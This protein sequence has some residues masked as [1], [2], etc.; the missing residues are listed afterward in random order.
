MVVIG[1]KMDLVWV[2]WFLIDTVC[3][4]LTYATIQRHEREVSSEA[5]QDMAV[6]WGVPFY[7]T[8][9]KRGWRSNEVFYYLLGRMHSKYPGGEPKDKKGWR[10][11]CVIM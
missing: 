8:S 7:E 2:N 11:Q 3:D 1:T 5:M 10:V 4:A 6:K 9:V